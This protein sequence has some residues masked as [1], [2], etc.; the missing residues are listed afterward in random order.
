MTDYMESD[1]ANEISVTGKKKIAF[2]W[3]QS[4]ELPQAIAP[5]PLASQNTH[6]TPQKARFGALLGSG[7]TLSVL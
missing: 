6:E 1:V 4:S 2:L 7:P 3:Y 5:N